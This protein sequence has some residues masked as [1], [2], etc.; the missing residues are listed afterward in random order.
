MNF[1]AVKTALFQVQSESTVSNGT[2]N[3]T[4]ACYLWDHE[5]VYDAERA[6][7][8]KEYVKALFAGNLDEC[9]RIEALRDAL[10]A[11]KRVLIFKLMEKIPVIRGTKVVMDGKK[12]KSP[13]MRDVDTIYIPEDSVKL[14]LVEYEETDQT[15]PDASGRQATV[16]NLHIIK[17]LLDV[18]EAQYDRN[19][20][21]TRE[22]RAN[23]T[24]ISY[25][26]M[27]IAG[28]ILYT[29]TLNQRK[30]FGFEDSI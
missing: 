15:M 19:D 10:P 13:V 2:T 20:R 14:G 17:G 25:R 21:M 29:E 24:P 27:Q 6:R 4:Y 12:S 18:K 8:D 16:I 28:K 30:S 7:L 5:N 23:L 11:T 22:S 3:S 26:S 9:N 1:E